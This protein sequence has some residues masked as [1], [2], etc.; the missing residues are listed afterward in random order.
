MRFIS[1][2]PIKNMDELFN[3]YTVM[4]LAHLSQK[5]PEYAKRAAEYDGYKIMDNSIIEIGEAFTMEDLMKEADKCKVQEIILPDVF[6]DGEATVEKVKE[7]IQWLHEHDYIGKYKLM[8]VC[9]GKNMKELLK[10]FNILN[11]IPEIDVIGL[12]KVLYL[13]M[14]YRIDFARQIAK[15]TDKE[16]HLLGC[17]ETL[18][19]YMDRDLSFIRSTD[20]CLPALLTKYGLTPRS[21]RGYRKLDLENDEVDITQ[22]RKLMKDF[23]KKRL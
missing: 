1:I 13:W 21:K 4:L 10:S 19:E 14:G 18:R 2:L 7:S 5:Y 20:T 9:H 17:W 22:Y 11:N 12:P 6:N 3:Q 15:N 23:Y 16:I 8:A